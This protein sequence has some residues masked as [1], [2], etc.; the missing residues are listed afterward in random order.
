MCDRVKLREFAMIGKEADESARP[1]CIFDAQAALSEPE[2]TG[3]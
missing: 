1:L 2:R 3:C